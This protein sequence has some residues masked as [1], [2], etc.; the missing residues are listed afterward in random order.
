LANDSSHLDS[1]LQ[2][3]AGSPPRRWKHSSFFA[4]SYAKG[5][6]MAE[7]LDY[8]P[9]PAKVVGDIQNTWAAE[10]KDASGKALY[11]AST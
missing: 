6:K 4:W 3:A 1:D 9:T 7:D 10:I 5:E 2:E 11:V 8:V